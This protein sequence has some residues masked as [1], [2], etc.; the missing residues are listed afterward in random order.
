MGN[1]LYP[2][3]VHRITGIDGGSYLG[4]P[5]RG[6]WHE[7]ITAPVAFYRS[8]T[9]YHIQF[10]EW[11]LGSAPQIEQHI[12]FDVASRGLRNLTSSQRIAADLSPEDVATNRMGS[13]NINAALVGYQTGREGGYPG[14][15]PLSEA[16]V[17]TLAAFM[18]WCEKEWD[19]PADVSALIDQAGQQEYGYLSPLRMSNDE[20][21][22]F[23]GWCGHELVTENTHHDPYWQFPKTR[24]TIEIGSS[25]PK[26]DDMSAKELAEGLTYDPAR[27]DA[28]VDAG[29]IKPA[30]GQTLAQTKAFWRG[31][32]D[33][34]DDPQW[35]NF[36]SAVQ[37]ATTL[38]AVRPLTI[39]GKAV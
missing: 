21:E 15:Y 32:L 5:P 29:V 12:P 4:G 13:V 34:P 3:A 23:T 24:L 35:K 19:I 20:W 33:T 27:I 2:P 10:R 22:A 36:F 38:G 7:T 25:R 17:D 6:V 14:L 37:V 26:G 16:M 9:Y 31:L 11:P 39:T 18:L 1:P 8:A 28:L 30:P